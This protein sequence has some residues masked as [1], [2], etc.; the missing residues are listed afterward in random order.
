MFSINTLLFL[1]SG[2]LLVQSISAFQPALSFSSPLTRLCATLDPSSA[3]ETSV[4]V[5]GRGYISLL[6][7]KMAALRG[8]QTVNFVCPPGEEETVKSLLGDDPATSIP[9]NLKLV[10]AAETS[11]LEEAAA[12]MSALIIAVDDT[13][14]LDAGVVNYLL[15]ADLATNCR[16]V[17]AM[18]RNLNNKNMGFLVKAS[19]A[20][21]NREVWD[22]SNK[23]E[24]EVFEKAVRDACSKLND[25]EWTVVRAGTLKGGGCGLKERTDSEGNI[26]EGDATNPEYCP[27]YLSKKFYELTKKDIVTWNLL[28]DCAVRGVKLSKGDVLPGPGGKAIFTATSAEVCDG[29]SS[30][31][32]VAEAMVR[33]LER[34]DCGNVDFGVGTAAARV[35]PTEEEWEDTYTEAQL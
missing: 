8:Y 19:K 12:G 9:P 13:S 3:D 28:F 11:A 15:D 4:T 10:P 30:R 6:A 24:F 26:I 1:A 35:P 16:R 21:A 25:C 33:S 14:T 5:I 18:S 23:E 7:A 34:A 32:A 27:Q 29:D 17:V 22:N 31:A 20:T 2:C